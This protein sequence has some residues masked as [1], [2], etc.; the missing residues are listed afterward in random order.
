MFEEINVR[1]GELSTGSMGD[2][3]ARS[4]ALDTQTP[5]PAILDL[6]ATIYWTHNV[7]QGRRLRAKWQERFRRF[8]AASRNRLSLLSIKGF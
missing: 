7:W 8:T 4:L 1:I 3:L 6:P 5:A 2:V